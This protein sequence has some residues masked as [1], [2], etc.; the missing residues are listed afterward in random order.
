MKL[1]ISLIFIWLIVPNAAFA[2]C[3][4]CGIGDKKD[5]HKECSYVKDGKKVNCSAKDHAQ[6]PYCNSKNKTDK[7]VSQQTPPTTKNTPATSSTTKSAPATKNT[8]A[9]SSTTKSAPATKNTPAT[10]STTKSAPATKNTPAT[11][12]TPPKNAAPVTKTSTQK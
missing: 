3:G 8:P 12:S 2:H 11:Q 5:H 7:S 10:S 4:K 9:T 6:C 1:L